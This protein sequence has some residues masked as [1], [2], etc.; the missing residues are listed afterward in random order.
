MKV[1]VFDIETFASEKSLLYHDFAYLR[2]RKSN[3]TEEEIIDSLSLNFY[4]SN[5][6]AVSVSYI[7]TDSKDIEQTKVWYLTEAENEPFEENALYMG[8]S[9]KILYYPIKFEE[10]RLDNIFSKERELLEN[11]F[12]DIE[13]KGINQIVTFN[14]RNFDVGF[15]FIRGMIHGIELPEW[16]ISDSRSSKFHIDI[17]EFLSRGSFEGKFS[18]DFVLRHFG[19]KTSKEKHRGETVKDMFINEK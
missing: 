14:G 18:L 13:S 1:A 19:L 10:S 4:I 5:V 8:N 7:D 3:K 11:F 12:S 17:C 16:V 2:N 6:I 15:L 9:L